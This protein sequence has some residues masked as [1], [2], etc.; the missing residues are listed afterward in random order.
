MNNIKNVVVVGGGTG[1]SVLLSGLK[2]FP[3]KITAVVAVTDDGGS[4]GK[5]REMYDI[6]AMGDIRKVLSSLSDSKRA[7]ESLMEYSLEKI[8]GHKIGNLILTA[9]YQETGSLTE[10]TRMLSDVLKINGRVLPALEANTT[11]EGVTVNGNVIYGETSID[12]CNEQIDYIRYD[13]NPMVADE[14]I[15]AYLNADLIVLSM[16]SLFTSIIPPIIATKAKEAILKSNAKKLYICNAMSSSE[17]SDY[18]VSDF[19]NKLNQHM[20]VD[21]LDAVICNRTEVPEEIKELYR[22]EN[23]YPVEYDEQNI[24]NIEVILSDM[25]QIENNMVRHKSF[26][27]ASTIFTYL[28][29]QEEM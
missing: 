29:S 6:P 10:A 28:L 12:K 9:L 26:K 27:V 15:E 22:E 16:G 4:T 20:G 18:R 21:F 3:M 11:L 17:V 24:E 8:D 23:A 7:F 2:H 5:L 14:V 13:G 1:L 25:I 19:V